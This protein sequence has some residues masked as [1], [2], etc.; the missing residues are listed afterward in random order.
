MVSRHIAASPQ[1]PPRRRI[2]AGVMH[3]PAQRMSITME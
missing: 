1:T 2:N 3:T